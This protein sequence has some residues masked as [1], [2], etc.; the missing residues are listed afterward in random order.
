MAPWI[1]L[2]AAIASSV[3][4]FAGLADAQDAA[5]N[6]YT[7]TPNIIYGTGTVL[8]DG[9]EVAKDLWLDFWQPTDGLTEPRL[10]VIFTHAR[11]WQLAG[12]R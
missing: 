5:I 9:K 2:N 7:I 4:G 11:S 10:T 8:D 6:R 12:P 3:L 1:R